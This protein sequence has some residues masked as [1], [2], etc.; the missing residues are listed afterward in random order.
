MS[1]FQIN[2]VPTFQGLVSS[3]ARGPHFRESTFQGSTGQLR[4]I[5][6]LV[7]VYYSSYTYTQ[8]HALTQADSA[9]SSVSLVTGT[10]E[11]TR[12]VNTG[13]IKITVICTSSTLINIYYD[14]V[15]LWS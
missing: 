2:E 4:L 5:L 8:V 13:S 1:C 15:H 3:I 12:S 9:I 11:A 6:L 10:G 7:A 14:K